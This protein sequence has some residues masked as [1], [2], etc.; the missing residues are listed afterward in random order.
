MTQ[1]PER[2]HQ[3]RHHIEQQT[4][5]KRATEHGG[6][7]QHLRRKRS[8]DGCVE[9]VLIEQSQYP[10]A[11]RPH[12]QVG[13][14]QSRQSAHQCQQQVLTQHLLQQTAARGSVGLA[15]AQFGDAAVHA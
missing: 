4:H 15:N 3:R 11:R 7:E 6:A 10:V 12:Y 9:D 2:G 14:Q 8:R 13:E 5:A 1:R